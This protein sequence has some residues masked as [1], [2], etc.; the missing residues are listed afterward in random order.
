MY[1]FSWQYWRQ[2]L[3]EWVI[4]RHSEWNYCDSLRSGNKHKGMETNNSQMTLSIGSVELTPTRA[5]YLKANFKR[6]NWYERKIVV[7][8]SD[9][10]RSK[11]RSSIGYRNSSRCRRRRFS[12]SK[13]NKRTIFDHRRASQR[14]ILCICSWLKIPNGWY[15]KFLQ[16]RF[17]SITI[18][19]FE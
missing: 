14:H 6:S 2:F 5:L 12:L 4:L 9:S 7:F 10:N 3:L 16:E 19:T 17:R 8:V 11:I 13:V 1:L 18:S 15:S